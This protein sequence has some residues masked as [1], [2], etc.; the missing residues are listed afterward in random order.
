MRRALLVGIDD[1]DF[2][3]LTGCVNDATNMAE[4]LS[5][6]ED[7]LPN[8]DCKLITAPDEYIS[9]SSFHEQIKILFG[10]EADVALL[11]F[12]GH[13]TSDD[14]G[15]SLVTQ[16]SSKGDEGI[17]MRDVLS[18]ANKSKVREVV[19][20]LDCC[21]S[22]SFGS[23]PELDEDK[24]ILREGVSI[25][26]ATRAS[27]PAVEIGG[28]GLFT[29]LVRNALSGGAADIC[30]NVTVAG[31]YAYIDQALGAWEQRPLFKSHVSRFTPLRKCNPDIELS[32]LRLLAKYFPNPDYKIKLDP[33]YEPDAE[34]KNEER[35]E[36]FSHL[37]KYR[38]SRL[39]VPIGEEHMY[40]AAMNSKSCKL[41]PIGQYYWYLAD[42]GKI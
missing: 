23:T 40:Y 18:L 6:N 22:G 12:A 38:A 36:I 15:G 41:T 28:G 21:F 24:A 16:D 29:F 14:L 33:S 39:V 20:I 4:L 27:Q 31:V 10:N 3:P 25:L 5:H 30:G 13:G 11:Y 42:R 34:P 17:A 19:I 7:G 32:I 37:Q 8:F 9:K 26:T 1:Y 2:G 35:Q